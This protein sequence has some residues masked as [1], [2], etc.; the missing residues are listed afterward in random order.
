MRQQTIQQVMPDSEPVIQRSRRGQFRKTAAGLLPY[1]LL[2]VIAVLYILPFLWLIVTSLKPMNQIFSDPIRWLPD[3]IRWENYT[4]ALTSPAFPFW[5]L[6]RNT[7]FYAVLST[8]GIVLSSAVVAYG[9]ARLEFWGRDLLFGITLATMMLPAVVTFIPT[10]ILFR[11]FNWVGTYAPLLVPS[12]FGGAFNIFLLRQF[13][14]TIPWDLTDAAR[15]DGAS[16][17]TILWR[18]MLPLVKPALLVVAVMHFLFTWNDFFG[19]LIY[20]DDTSEYPLVLGLY[21]FQTRRGVQ[22]NHLMAASL[23]VTFP[24]ILLFFIAQRYFIE[25]VT[26]S[27]LKG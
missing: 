21:A 7:L 8:F 9:F 17:F 14:L 11:A 19:P 4:E 6:L 2:T 13:M 24:L 18:I 3:P 23:T 20:L 10:Y 16:E 27:G 12:F 15:V 5:L 25:G 22:W 26:L 1:L